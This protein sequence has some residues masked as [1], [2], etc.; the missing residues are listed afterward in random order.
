M[1]KEKLQSKEQPVK[2]QKKHVIFCLIAVLI[3][4]LVLHLVYSIIDEKHPQE[5]RT[6][7]E[8]MGDIETTPKKWL[9]GYL[10]AFFRFKQLG[11][12][13]WLIIPLLI[14][15]LTTKKLKRERW[16]WALLLVWGLTVV[17]IGIKGYYNFRYQL[18]LFPITS[19][20]VLFLLWK[21]LENKSRILKILCF[22]LVILACLFNI[23]HYF[24]LYKTYWGLRVS[25]DTPHFPYR[26]MEYFKTP[27]FKGGA[28]NRAKVLT[29]NQP[30]YYYH[31]PE[32][33]VDYVGPG[34]IKVW[35]EFKKSTGTVQSRTRLFQYLKSRFGVE[36]ILLSMIHERFHRSTM[37]GEFLH[38]ECKLVVEDQNWLLYRLRDR[39]LQK[40]LSFPGYKQV[41]VWNEKNSKAASTSPVNF[42]SISPSLLRF[43]RQGIFKFEPGAN[44]GENIIIVSNTKVKG[45]EKRR[46]HFGYEFNRKGLNIENREYEGKYV[47]FIVRTAISPYL[48][49][50]ENYIAVV[51]YNQDGTH[52]AE[53][54]YFTSHHWRTYIVSN[55]V[56]SGS[57]RLLLMFRFCP[58]SEKDRFRIKDVKVIISDKPLGD[59]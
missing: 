59:R 50:R 46:I 52:K 34:A 25:V 8:Y 42:Q 16:Q 26:L 19:A 20:M 39:P 58:Q 36:Y 57:K 28:E 37:L 11:N 48:L 7:R 43:S 30:I 31:V 40:V 54:T 18:T 51:D 17:F 45:K 6:K 33:G 55:R 1:K 22:S 10:G 49:N 21:F 56:R 9:N 14:W 13:N 5:T 2:K 12:I 32:K 23:Y 41:Q 38:S 3:S 29:I 15:F 24:N 4:V 27:E 47:A 53:K 35:V 44:E